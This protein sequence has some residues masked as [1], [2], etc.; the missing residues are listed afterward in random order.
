MSLGHTLAHCTVVRGT[1]QKVLFFCTVCGAYSTRRC[2]LSGR[3][4]QQRK[5]AGGA[6]SLRRIYDGLFPQANVQAEVS[7]TS[8]RGVAN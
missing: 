8:R 6:T 3:E 1:E 7:T 2:R 4:C 5:L